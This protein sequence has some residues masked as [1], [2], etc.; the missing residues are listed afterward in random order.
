MS[1]KFGSSVKGLS[2][3]ETDLT[4]RK[5]ITPPQQSG[6]F[7]FS[8]PKP[9]G[10]VIGK[11]KQQHFLLSPENRQH[12][13]HIVGSTGTGKS[14]FLELLVRYDLSDR[15]VGLCLL[16]PHGSLYD[17]VLHY[18]AHEKPE[19]A[20]RL[21]LFNPAEETKNIIG[22]NPVIADTQRLDYLIDSLVQAC[23][24]AWGQ[25]DTDR[26]PRIT[27]W[28]NNI[29]HTLICND[30]TLVESSPLISLHDKFHR[31]ILLKNVHDIDVLN[32][33]RMFETSSNTQ[34]QTL[35]EGAANRLR[36]FLRNETIRNIIG[37]SERV[38]NFS[39]VMDEGKIVLVNLNGGGII[40]HD[41]SKLLGVLL[42]NEIFRC[43]K[44]RNP[45]DAD[46]KPFYFYIDEFA[47]FLTRDIARTLEE[48]RKFKLF[49]VLAHQHLAQLKQEDE[50]LYASVLTNCKNKVVFGGLSR[51]DAQI[52][53]DEIATGFANLK[54][55]KDELYSTKERRR[56]EKRTVKNSSRGQSEGQSEGSSEGFTEGTASS[57]S[58]TEGQSETF[59]Q[60]IQHRE[61]Q[62]DIG[63]NIARRMFGMGDKPSGTSQSHSQ[64]KTL[65]SGRS[66]T[67]SQSNNHSTSVSS[68]SSSSTSKGES[69]TWVSVG[70]EYQ[71]LSSRTFWSLQELEYMQMADLKN[72][73]VA[74]AFVKCWG[75]APV[76]VQI[77]N[78]ETAPYTA[79]SQRMIDQVRQ[80]AIAAHPEYFTDIEAVVIERET[81]QIAAFGEP[82]QLTS[83]ATKSESNIRERD[84]DDPFT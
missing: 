40:S 17:E 63:K 83:K 44:L 81:R 22:F 64:G 71:E 75:E 18:V 67:T 35:I 31:E 6:G 37:Q 42:V 65:Q 72:Q 24:K 62:R 16:D 9:D 5:N 51:E 34:K 54:S 73:G 53:S 39:E 55:V 49:M 77:A 76:Q 4:R 45:R 33:W 1:F 46:L 26:T 11:S 14:K 80:A 21:I 69:E 48:A 15:K 43:A 82:L 32:D 19:L 7:K 25:D 70:D 28:L 52:M 61:D 2:G 13:T 20:D 84:A 27:K 29:F 50:Y 10:L 47:Q 30:L 66:E 36:K 38:L 74:Q 12:H 78:I 41:N 57:Y 8:K 56:L 79:D 23:L 58:E 59:G 68:S 60:G 3:N